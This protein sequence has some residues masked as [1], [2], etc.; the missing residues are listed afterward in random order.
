MADY[1]LT[2]TGAEVQ[3]ILDRATFPQITLNVPVSATNGT[4]T[5]SQL[6]TLQKNI[7]HSSVVLN[8][9]I[10]YCMDNQ[11]TTG[12]LVYSHVGYEASQAFLKTITITISTLGW[13]LSTLKLTATA[14]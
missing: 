6:Q 1:K 7:T 10:F 8:Q 3:Q 9:E 5:T 4:I 2:Q 11:H 14:V 13:V 12:T